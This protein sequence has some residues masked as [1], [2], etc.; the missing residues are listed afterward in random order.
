[1]VG[2][3]SD[4]INSGE[5]RMNINKFKQAD[6]SK[7][8]SLTL[9]TEK[10]EFM[11]TSG[12]RN[13]FD[14]HL[15]IEQKSLCV[16]YNKLFSTEEKYSSIKFIKYIVEE[17]NAK[18]TLIKTDYGREYD[19]VFHEYCVKAGI[20]HVYGASPVKVDISSFIDEIL[21]NSIRV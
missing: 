9:E 14:V 10:I 6:M 5:K 2:W 12:Q 4:I 7:G 20:D 15:A 11:D 17:C 18:P 8:L 1:M 13:V 16:M 21:N 19:D 3:W